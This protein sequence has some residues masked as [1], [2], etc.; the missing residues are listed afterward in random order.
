MTKIELEQMLAATQ[1]M[2]E[3]ARLVRYIDI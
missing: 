2:A 3:T 1:A